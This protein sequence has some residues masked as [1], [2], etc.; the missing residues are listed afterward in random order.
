MTDELRQCISNICKNYNFPDVLRINEPVLPH[1]L[2]NVYVVFADATTSFTIDKTELTMNGI[3]SPK[4]Y[5]KLRR[6]IRARLG[7]A[8]WSLKN[9][10]EEMLESLGYDEK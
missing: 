6:L 7:N 8:A 3:K 4:D 9:L 10:A 2:Q 5:R 1:A